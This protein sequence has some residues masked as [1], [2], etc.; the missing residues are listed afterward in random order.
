MIWL[1]KI[2]VLPVL[3]T[4]L[5]IFSITR[6]V[7]AAVLL[8]SAVSLVFAPLIFGGLAFRKVRRKYPVLQSMG[9]ESCPLCSAQ[10]R[11][12]RFTR[13]LL[14]LPYLFK[15]LRHYEMMHGEIARASRLTRLSFTT[16]INLFLVSFASLV[17]L[18]NLTALLTPQTSF[19]E[20]TAI[21]LL[22]F[23]SVLLILWGI[24]AYTLIWKHG[25]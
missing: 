18:R 2:Y 5:F 23:G 4:F 17:G 10:I 16:F 1:S 22:P 19:I 13:N 24:L 15:T 3:I 6:H 8:V 14:L 21:F 20:A 11:K 7:V 25:G 12:E 9:L